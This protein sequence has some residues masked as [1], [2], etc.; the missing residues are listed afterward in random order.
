MHFAPLRP[1]LH[2]HSSQRSTKCRKMSQ[3]SPRKAAWSNTSKTAC[4][5]LGCCCRSWRSTSERANR[6]G[7]WAARMLASSPSPR[8]SS[9]TCGQRCHSSV[10]LTA[11]RHKRCEAMPSSWP[12]WPKRLRT[13]GPRSLLSACKRC[14]KRLSRQGMPLLRQVPTQV[15][16]A[17]TLSL[18]LLLP[19]QHA[20]HVK[21]RPGRPSLPC[22]L[23]SSSLAAPAL[24]RYTTLTHRSRYVCIG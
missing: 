22:K 19:H 14:G 4:P 3:I 10:W 11:S 24:S 21:T 16:S 1:T 6:S 7:S 23:P 13:C 5:S 8:P 2:A 17:L 18:P 9:P 20:A 12:R 15:L